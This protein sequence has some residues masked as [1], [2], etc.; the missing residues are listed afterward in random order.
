MGSPEFAI[1][2]LK[3]LHTQPDCNLIAVYTQPPKP[4]GRGLE[5]QPTPVEI[6]AREHNIPVY[7][8]K[9]F[10]DQEDINFF[11]S[12]N[13]D[14]VIVAAYGLILPKDILYTPK[15][16][17]INIHSSLLPRWRGAAPIHHAI[18]AGDPST[19]VT[20]MQMDEGLD[21]G[22]IILKSEHLI[23]DD[24]T[25][26]K[27]LHDILAKLGSELTLKVV[28]KILNNENLIFEKQ[29][30]SKATYA[31]KINKE[32]H[33]INWQNPAHLVVRQI[34]ALSENG[35]YITIN[36][37][38]IKI[39]KAHLGPQVNSEPGIILDADFN[40]S[41]GDFTSI[42]PLILQRAGKNPVNLK[43]FLNGFKNWSP[44]IKLS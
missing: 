32:L 10:K 31:S 17:A 2:S 9:N 1:P 14:L 22:D 35:C 30:N 39:F 21:T 20:I 24:K 11:K 29:D 28:N 33:K 44:G 5:L 41:C 43:Q 38:N 7:S 34:N 19:G 36:N 42:N 18:L 15:Y 6:Y 23:I 37:E 4:K 12:L 16:G 27:D 26:F 3:M 25:S 40:I 8:P 13:A